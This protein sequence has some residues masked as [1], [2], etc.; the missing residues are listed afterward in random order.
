MCKES[1]RQNIN[2]DD[3]LKVLDEMEFSE[4]VEPLRTWL[5]VN[6]VVF[7]LLALC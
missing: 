6:L 5:K 7:I 4:F 1:K 2:I 3:A